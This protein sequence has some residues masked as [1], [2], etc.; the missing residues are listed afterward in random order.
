MFSKVSSKR[1]RSGSVPVYL[2]VYDLTPMNGYIYWFGLGV[3]HSGV[4]VHG[5]EYAFGAHEYPTSGVFEVE[6]KQCPGF[7]FRKSI[8]IGATDFGPEE[9]RNFMEQ[10]AGEYNGN[11][12]QLIAKNCNHFCNDVCLKLT[13]NSIPRWVN[14]LARIG[15]LCNCVLPVGL[16]V[17]TVPHDPEFRLCDEEKKELSRSFSRFSSS[18][19]TLKGKQKPLS[20]PNLLISSSL[21]GGVLPWEWKTQNMVK[22]R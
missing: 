13:R 3:Y 14:R 15:L 5:V 4:E 6:P 21:K 18:F 22:Y 2:N 20:V 12:Y 10:L 17:A 9:V 1:V 8:L 19:P 16:H 7:T 11:T